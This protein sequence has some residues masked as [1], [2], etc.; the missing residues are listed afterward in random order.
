MHALSGLN[1]SNKVVLKVIDSRR[2]R[3]KPDKVWLYI[4]GLA[5]LIYIQT[6]KQIQM[7]GM[8]TMQ[9]Q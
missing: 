5:K 2:L 6:S 8:L 7:N 9:D 1:V 4:V 3:K